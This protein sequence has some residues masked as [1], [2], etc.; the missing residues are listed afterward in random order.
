V[1]NRTRST[2]LSSAVFWVKGIVAAL[3][4]EDLDV[5][6]LIRE[7]GLS[8]AAL[9]SPDARVPTETVS[10]LWRLAVERSGNPAAGLT[11]AMVNHR[12]SM[13][14]AMP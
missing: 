10:R 9:D 11:G 5:H 13:S 6:A 7:A 4:Q 12:F 3:K 14:S 8:P 2:R 1:T